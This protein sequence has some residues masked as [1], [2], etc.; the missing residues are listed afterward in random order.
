MKIKPFSY[1]F[2]VIGLLFSDSLVIAQETT[3]KKL[4]VEELFS[5][6]IENNPTLSVSKAGVKIAK[7]NVEV[8]KNLKLPDVNISANAFYIGDGLLIN[9]DFSKTTTVKMP[10]FGNS[11]AIEAT[12][13]IWKGGMV[14]HTI[15]AKSLQEDLATLN[16]QF[17]EQNIK[18]LS[19]GYYLDLYK[20]QNQA[21]VYRKNIQLAEQRLQNIS[22]FYKE[23]MV[24]RNDV[25]RGELQISNLNLALQVI[26]NNAQILN[27]QLLVAL[28]LSDGIQIVADENLLQTGS[29][30]SPLDFYRSNGINHPLVLMSQKGIELSEAA[31]KI[32]KSE[33]L[34][35]LAAF[36]GN[37]LQRPITTTSPAL[38]M[39]SNGWNVGLSLSY[40]IGSLYKSS[41]KI[42]TNR[43]ELEK[44]KAQENEAGK[45]IEVA[46]NAA[47]I[48][49]KETRSQNTTLAKNR[50]LTEENYRIME[51]KYNNQLAI[52]LDMIDASNA[53]LDA[54]LQ[55][56]N[57]EINIVFAYY[58]LLKESGKI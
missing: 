47:Y 13:L 33:R 32:T 9:K 56:T 53:K 44:A 48:K 34:P 4:T 39:Y 42:Q 20:L 57:S 23:G 6:V 51:S 2:W 43:Y 26:E 36:V 17:N 38:D 54:E 49:Y 40:D 30:V 15:E 22:R 8:A 37:K 5:L 45:M 28:G 58:K 41:K 12:Q 35:T 27:K 46:I 24:T 25:I 1:L 52:L 55:Y 50:D 3:R 16:Y 10:H 29:G 21:S 14:Q 7:Q 18:L 11:Y 31:T 19:L